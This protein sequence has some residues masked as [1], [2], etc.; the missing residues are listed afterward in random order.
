MYC[1]TKIYLL[2]GFFIHASKNSTVQYHLPE[3]YH[4][5]DNSY[6]R[7]LVLI[8]TPPSPTPKKQKL[9]E[10]FKK[11]QAQEVFAT[12]EN[13]FAWQKKIT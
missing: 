11:V 3:Q 9:I 8:E 6:V 13:P 1:Y 2:Y 12:I 4:A 7:I 10:A 5:Y